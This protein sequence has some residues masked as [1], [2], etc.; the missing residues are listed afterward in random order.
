MHAKWADLSSLPAVQA[1]YAPDE[2]DPDR[3]PLTV[4]D[5]LGDS[6]HLSLLPGDAPSA[7]KAFLVS[8]AA[9]LKS[10]ATAKK[11][12]ND[13]VKNN[14]KVA[15]ER[16]ESILKVIHIAFELEERFAISESLDRMETTHQSLAEEEEEPRHQVV[17]IETKNQASESDD[18]DDIPSP[19]AFLGFTGR[20]IP[21]LY[22]DDSPVRQVV[23]RNEEELTAFLTADSY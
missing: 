16:N 6:L 18:S 14:F 2:Q 19:L 10:N 11:Q 23:I 1:L 22:R 17:K 4:R 12:W 9:K 21:D 13:W 3:L 8:I 15:A 5:A 20:P 7:R